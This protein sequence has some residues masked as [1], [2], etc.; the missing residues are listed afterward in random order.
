MGC[1]DGEGHGGVTGCIYEF[2]SPHAKGMIAQTGGH[3]GLD[4]IRASDAMMITGMFA[5]VYSQVPFSWMSPT[6][7]G[8]AVTL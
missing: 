5:A 3:S 6:F 4:I 7:H 8:A 2:A 1:R